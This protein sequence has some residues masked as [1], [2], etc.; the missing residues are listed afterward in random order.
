MEVA[1]LGTLLTFE[2]RHYLAAF[3]LYVVEKGGALEWRSTETRV[4]A[5]TQE[6]GKLG[7]GCLPRRV[8]R[9]YVLG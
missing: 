4:L 9:G 3:K 1:G 8:G 5:F 7:H 6:N 2:S